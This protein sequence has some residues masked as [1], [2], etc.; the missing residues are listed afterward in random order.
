MRFRTHEGRKPLAQLRLSGFN[1]TSQQGMALVLVLWLVVL[2]SMLATGHTRNAHTETKLAAM[3]I[4]RAEARAFAEAGVNAAILDLLRP[5]TK[6]QWRVDG[7]LLSF[8]FDGQPI[9][10]SIRDATGLIDLNAASAGLLTKLIASADVDEAAQQRIVDAILDWRDADEFNHLYGAE[11]D[12]YRAAGLSWSARDGDFAS[13]DE[14]Q[15]VMGM[16]RNVFDSVAPYLTVYAGTAGVNLEFAPPA[17]IT[18]LTGQEIEVVEA[19]HDRA[20]NQSDNATFHIQVKT[21][22]RDHRYYSLEVVVQ[23]LADSQIPFAILYWREA[24][25]PSIPAMVWVKA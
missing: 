15:Y 23:L 25:R 18:V 11:D 19:G 10:V 24:S 8:E 1:S 2:L 14:L 16:S 6:R 22:Q 21:A 7:T 3:H 9:A 12:D 5:S 4:N 13:V 17:L 20:N